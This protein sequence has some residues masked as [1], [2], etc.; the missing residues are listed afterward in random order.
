M[1]RRAAFLKS[2]LKDD[3]ENGYCVEPLKGSDSQDVAA[4]AMACIEVQNQGIER[5]VKSA[6]SFCDSTEKSKYLGVVS[7]GLEEIRM[8]LMEYDVL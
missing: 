5:F 4:A 2:G 6:L 8:L 1:V 3:T 7:R